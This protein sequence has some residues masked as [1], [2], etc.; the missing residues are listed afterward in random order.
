MDSCRLSDGS[1]NS[2]CRGQALSAVEPN[3]GY[4][5]FA[6]TTFGARKD[7]SVEAEIEYLRS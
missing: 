3:M 7:L 1:M 4:I 2:H 6:N 5:T